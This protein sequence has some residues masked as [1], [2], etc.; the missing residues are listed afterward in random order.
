MDYLDVLVVCSAPVDVRPALNLAQEIANFE[1]EVRRAPIPIRLR[2]VFP[3]TLEQ[4]G[5]VLSPTALRLWQP[6]VFHFLGHGEEDGLWFEREDGSGERVPASHLRR[7][8]QGSPIR[9]ALLNACWSA[10]DRVL[11][12]CEHL[13]RDGIVATAIG[14]G[15]PV[16]DRSAIEFARRFYAGLTQ[17]HPVGKACRTAANSL[18]EH[19]LLGAHEIELRGDESLRLAADLAPGERT[20]RVEDGMPARGYF[21]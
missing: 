1:H 21:R 3:P 5:R 18:A 16:A 19:G 14:H 2:R 9:L 15:R 13:T 4:L 7:V 6:R 10:T 11:S 12:L 17:G 20:G 8:F